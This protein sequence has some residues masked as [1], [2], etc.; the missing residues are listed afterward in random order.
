MKKI[1]FLFLS[2]LLA[3][4]LFSCSEDAPIEDDKQV[5]IYE[6]MTVSSAIK[7]DTL[8]KA[9]YARTKALAKSTSS[10]NLNKN[11]K[12][13][14]ITSSN[15]YA[16]LGEDIFITV[17]IKN[18]DKFEILS[19]TLN[20][21]KYSSYMFERGSDMETI[22]IKCNVGRKSGKHNYTIDAIKYVD[23]SAIKDVVIG[24][25]QTINVIVSEYEH[26]ANCKHD[27]AS[28]I[29]VFEAITP[30]CEIA[31]LTEGKKCE[32]C[33][34]VIVEQEPLP[35]LE[36]TPGDWIID[37]AAAPNEDG[38]KHTECTACG[39]VVNKEIISA[40]VSQGL[41]YL[42]NP[43][44]K[45]CTIIGIGT[46]T[47]LDIVIPE[48]IEGYKVTA[49]GENAFK[50]CKSITSIVIPQYVSEIGT[51]AFMS[52]ESM[53]SA[54]LPAALKVI[55]EEGFY[56][57]SS[58]KNVYYEGD[59][60]GWCAIDFVTGWSSP[61]GHS[62]NLYF[63][64]TLV[65]DLVIPDTV[66]KIDNHA[67]F[68]CNSITSVI[69]G[70]GVTAI[71]DQAFS[72]C[73]NLSQITL[74]NSVKIIEDCAFE[75]APITSIVIPDSVEYIGCEAFFCCKSLKNVILGDSVRYVHVGAF[76]DAPLIEYNTYNNGLYLGTK[77]NPHHLLVSVIDKSVSSFEI[78]ENAKAIIGE[79]FWGC[80]RLTSITIPNGITHIS[81]HA[82]QGCSSLISITLP[83]SLTSIDEMAFYSCTSL[84]NIVIPEGVTNIGNSAFSYCTSLQSINIPASVT[85]I[86][87]NAFANCGSLTE[88]NVD[89]NNEY[90]KSINGILCSADGKTLIKYASKENTST[91][92]IPDGIL[93]IGKNAFSGRSDL[94]E[95]TIP[96]SVISI[97]SYAF[98][99]CTS[100]KSIVIPNTITR[101]E[102]FTFDGCT[103]LT[104]VIIPSSV[105][106]IGRSAFSDCTSLKSIVIPNTITRI[107]AFTFD[108]CTSLTSV[109]IPSSVT[110]IGDR[111]FMDCTSLT[112]IVI[113]KSVATVEI[114]AFRDCKLLTIYCEAK[115]KPTAWSNQWTYNNK[116]V[117]W[118]YVV[119]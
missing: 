32:M 11:F 93:Y 49:I 76:L 8:S 94:V 21:E 54:T 99:D 100:L 116:S 15:Y 86:G 39:K 38:L 44:K 26:E 102:D 95:I 56:L 63:S 89:E 68:G 37:K 25:N 12:D 106:S 114:W 42:P 2:I 80:T 117:I 71:E 97:G 105:I 40:I 107:E 29:T 118:G 119:K 53:K 7:V 46:C 27:N 104:S 34:T 14:E 64:G 50:D 1:L 75:V 45:S 74:G 82:F 113:P 6:G 3:F 72:S 109:I 36:C 87:D 69:I 60:E 9:T 98:S 35:M 58:L 111:A 10:I 20:G 5:P 62:S 59:V 65:T 88:I 115:S 110:F 84:T 18:P 23:K 55:G 112:S 73:R 41:D 17:H 4:S 101:I 19:F 33:N 79:A 92:T 77:N 48:Y 67:F 13:I 66:T 31:G 70:N 78:N 91:Y 85:N 28:K 52:C 24:G 47:D 90:Y 22:I 61:L 108:G 30:T 57:C 51:R 43:D 16:D 103:S 83:E 96:N 81:W